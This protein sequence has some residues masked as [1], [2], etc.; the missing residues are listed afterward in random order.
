MDDGDEYLSDLTEGEGEQ[1]VKSTQSPS[2]KPKTRSKKNDAAGY[3]IQGALTAPRATTY[4]TQHLFGQ[5]SLPQ[6]T[7]L[8]NKFL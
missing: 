2:K 5:Y 3:R 6:F 7:T 1:D 4:N 8:S